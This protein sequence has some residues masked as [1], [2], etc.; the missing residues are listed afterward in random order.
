M[1]IY[2][3]CCIIKRWPWSLYT[4]QSNK[5]DDKFGKTTSNVTES[6]IPSASSNTQYTNGGSASAHEHEAAQSDD[7]DLHG[8]E[9]LAAPGLDHGHV[10]HFQHLE[11]GEVMTQ[12][13][14][15]FEERS[16]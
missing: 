2:G 3:S 14:L 10:A 4:S 12:V 15:T 5:E 1:K 9:E 13:Y 8:A 6:F 16:A 7:A 11:A